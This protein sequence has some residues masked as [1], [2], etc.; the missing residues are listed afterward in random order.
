MKKIVKIRSAVNPLSPETA[1]DLLV[2]LCAHYGSLQPIA[3]AVA[4][5]MISSLAAPEK[6]GELAVAL[7]GSGEV[8]YSTLQYGF[9]GVTIVTPTSGT[10]MTLTKAPHWGFDL[11]IEFPGGGSQC[12]AEAA[13]AAFKAAR[14]EFRAS[15]GKVELPIG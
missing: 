8:P 15:D 9:Y 2:G 7:T 10:K 11:K 12:R 13:L 5:A 4:S 3:E 14:V 6:L 1:K